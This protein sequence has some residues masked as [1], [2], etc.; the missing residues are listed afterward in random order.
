MHVYSPPV[1]VLSA[2]NPNATRLQP[3]E[4]TSPYPHPHPSPD[5]NPHPH[6]QGEHAVVSGAVP[7][8][9]P[10]SAWAPH[11]IGSGR[12]VVAADQNNVHGRAQVTSSVNPNPDR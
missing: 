5:P 3:L 7:L 4:L 2:L 10:Q 6:Y 9:I 12:W 8:A 1:P 11:K